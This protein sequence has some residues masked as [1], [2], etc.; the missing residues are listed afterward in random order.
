MASPLLLTIVYF[1]RL[2]SIYPSEDIAALF[3]VILYSPFEFSKISEAS[4]P[5]LIIFLQSPYKVNN[6]WFSKDTVLF[7]LTLTTAH[8]PE[9]VVSTS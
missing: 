8:S 5:P 2:N 3:A 6:P 1:P 4:A 9:V 7:F